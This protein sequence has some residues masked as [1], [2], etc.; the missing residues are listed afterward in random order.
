[1]PLLDQGYNRQTASL[2]VF[3]ISAFF[4]EYLVS[5]PLKT[6]KIWAFLGMMSQLPLAIISKF[7]EKNLGERWGNICI[8]ASLILGQPLCIM[9]YF[10]DYVI[11]NYNH[12]LL[13]PEFID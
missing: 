10:H 3:F 2:I 5:I 12:T 6:F 11:N 4:H 1:M 13:E 9:V 8:W 7:L